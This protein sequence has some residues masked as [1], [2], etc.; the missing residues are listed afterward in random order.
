MLQNLPDL[1]TFASCC[2]HTPFSQCL[3]LLLYFIPMYHYV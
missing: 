1:T 2:C 3:T